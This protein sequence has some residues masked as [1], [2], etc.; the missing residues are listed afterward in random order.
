MLTKR[1]NLME[2]ITGGNPDRIVN[3]YEAFMCTDAIYGMIM[4]DP[5]TAQ[6]KSPMPGG[7]PE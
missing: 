1:Q 7:Q 6:G 3:Q 4:G 2:T 5:I